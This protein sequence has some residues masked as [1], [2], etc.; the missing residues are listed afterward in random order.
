MPVTTL[1]TTADTLDPLFVS[2]KD[3]CRVLGL[4]KQTVHRLLDAQR[5]ESRYLGRRRLVVL[6]SLNAFLE[7]LSPLPEDE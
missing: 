5:I 3:A 7:D 1:S 4:S 6:S 2:I